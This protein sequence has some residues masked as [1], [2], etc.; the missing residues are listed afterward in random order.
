VV[1]GWADR[2][3][4]TAGRGSGDCHDDDILSA[5][6]ASQTEALD[7]LFAFLAIPSIFRRRS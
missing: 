3:G 2:S 6:E 1:E 7:R 5:I 4:E